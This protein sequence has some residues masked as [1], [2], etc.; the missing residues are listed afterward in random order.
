MNLLIIYITRLTI[1][2]YYLFLR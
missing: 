2:N 1:D